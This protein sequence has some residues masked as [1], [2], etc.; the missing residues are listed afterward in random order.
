MFKELFESFNEARND[1][2]ELEK[3]LVYF[4]G[5]GDEKAFMKM[6]AGSAEFFI[7]RG[8][9]AFGRTIKNANA[10][11]RSAENRAREKYIEYSKMYKG[12]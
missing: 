8:T 10:Y 2:A 9:D 3:R 1:K 6:D 7:Q 11:R 5:K 12:K 4:V